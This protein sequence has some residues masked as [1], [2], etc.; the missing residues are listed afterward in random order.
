M[1][2]QPN[3]KQAMNLHALLH[4]ENCRVLLHHKYSEEGICRIYMIIV[5]LNF[6]LEDDIPHTEI[7]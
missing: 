7:I 3:V 6:C 1:A 5:Q 4:R 2:A